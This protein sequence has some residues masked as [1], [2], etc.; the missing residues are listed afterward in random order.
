MTHPLDSI[1]SGVEFQEDE[2]PLK[3]NLSTRKTDV[4]F[5]DTQAA[6]RLVAEAPKPYVRPVKSNPNKHFAQSAQRRS[7]LQTLGSIG[8]LQDFY[9]KKSLKHNKAGMLGFSLANLSEEPEDLD[10]LPT[11]IAP[12]P[13]WHNLDVETD[14]DILLQQAFDDIESMLSTWS[15]IAGPPEDQE[16]VEVLPLL[17]S[18]TE[19]LN[20]VKNY[21]LHRH[22]LSDL[23]VGKLR[24][25]ALILLESMTH[26]ENKYRSLEDNDDG[27]SGYVYNTLDYGNLNTERDAIL[28]YLD[29][30]EKYGFNPPHHVGA[31][32][33]GY[34]AIIK[35]LMIKTSSKNLDIGS[36]TVKQLKV[37]DWLKNNVQWGNELARSYAMIIDTLESINLCNPVDDRQAF[38]ETLAEGVVLCNVYNGLVKKSRRSFGLIQKIHLDT[39]RT[40]RATE[41]LSF[42]STACKLRFDLTFPNYK[43]AEIARKTGI[44]L[45]MLEAALIL[46]TQTVAKE[47]RANVLETRRKSRF[48]DVANLA[49]Q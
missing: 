27:A 6:N 21:I 48:I 36:P 12:P 45:D 47:F 30:I 37:S 1:D 49:I 16:R 43:P 31:P 15:M 9:G 44:G 17:Q 26:L 14:L 28:A 11:P 24:S 38:L 7:S 35:N 32:Y 3:S 20:T 39:Q 18:V 29:T 46:F 13:S 10:R 41:N 34:S 8:R 23:A 19:M 22:D 42:F 2:F 5:L 4:S 25:A 33:A 40:Y